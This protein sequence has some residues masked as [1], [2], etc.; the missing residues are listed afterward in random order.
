MTDIKVSVLTPIYNVEKYLEECL[1][2]L[3][4]QT[5]KEIEFI[6]I[7]DGSTDS[8]LNILRSFAARDS[9]FVVID[10]PNGGYGQTM[11]LGLSLAKGEYIGIVESDD[12]V[13]N[14]AFERLYELA[15]LNDCDFIR[16]NRYNF[17][18][19]SDAFCEDLRG[20]PYGKVVSPAEVAKK[21]F[22]T[23]PCIWSALYKKSFLEE[24]EIDFLETPGAS[25]QDTGFVMK[26]YIA[27]ERAMFVKDAYLHYRV[28]NANS[29]VK[30]ASKVFC[31]VDELS[32]VD[33]YLAKRPHKE[34]VLREMCAKRRFLIYRWN[35][36]RLNWKGRKLFYPVFSKEFA[37]LKRDGC[38]RKE[39]YA[40]AD[41]DFLEQLVG[42]WRLVLARE[43][44]R[45][46]SKRLKKMA[47]SKV[48][49]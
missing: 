1:C 39:L 19:K 42:N 35:A 9:R 37:A 21:L 23:A 17:S 18:A 6:C 32:S 29:S 11:N 41:W 24:N 22:C 5:M 43:I 44:A 38:L 47:K 46:A 26:G 30:S 7:N 34:A 13:E 12:W 36:R 2:S 33:Q 10:K 31:V 8:S 40:T 15:K 14:D 48:R 4:K 45:G 16:G 49:R 25:F 28:D 27:A 3:E 20:I